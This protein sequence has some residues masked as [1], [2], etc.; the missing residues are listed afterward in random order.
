MSSLIGAPEGRL[1]LPRAIDALGEAARQAGRPGVVWIAGLVYP[2]VGI[3]AGA[4]W[5]GTRPWF[6]SGSDAPVAIDMKGGAVFDFLLQA[7]LPLFLLP[8]VAVVFLPLF[9][10]VAGLAKA[11]SAEAWRAAA[12]EHRNPTLASLWR[13]GEGLT[14]STYGLWLQLVL[15]QIAAFIVL[16]A[17]IL[18]ATHPL[19]K[20][21]ENERIL[22]LLGI[23]AIVGPFILLFGL[24]M[25]ALSVLGQLALQSLAE[26]RR[27]VSSALLHAWRIMRHDP[28]A[29]ARA[30]V[31]EVLLL[32]L[33]LGF[34][35]FVGGIVEHVPGGDTVTLILQIALMGFA[36]VVR[37]GYWARAYRALG[38][39]TP[40]DGVPGLLRG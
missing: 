29:T 5:H 34:V 1:S 6:T 40:S 27:G 30:V 36:G 14:F 31:A 13:L 25:L 11:G 17:P 24:Y 3:G 39:L 22:A 28:W 8:F 15:M 10:L 21:P 23:G 4:G 32:V 9:R 26:N 16:L 35:R 18:A 20:V 37:A 2:A 33:T 19:G 7:Y 12:G 38:G